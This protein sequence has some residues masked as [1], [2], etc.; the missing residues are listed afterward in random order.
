MPLQ[1][2][3]TK[4]WLLQVSA[5]SESLQHEFKLAGYSHTKMCFSCD[6]DK[7]SLR[8][9]DYRVKMIPG[10]NGHSFHHDT[11]HNLEEGVASHAVARV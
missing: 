5:D 10:F 8:R 7:G 6:A 11:L 1:T 2:S 4:A 9:N 3:H